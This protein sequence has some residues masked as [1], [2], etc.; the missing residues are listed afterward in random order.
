MVD[1]VR[2]ERRRAPPFL[3]NFPVAVRRADK[4]FSWQAIEFSELGIRL[5]ASNKELIGQTLEMELPLDPDTPP[6]TIEGVV[7]YT[8]NT[9]IGI[10]FKNISHDHQSVLR[11]WAQRRA[12]AIATEGTPRP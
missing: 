6:L 12:I 3:V 10:R 5:A 4:Q 2:P 11:R 1:N 9:S 7:A 8:T